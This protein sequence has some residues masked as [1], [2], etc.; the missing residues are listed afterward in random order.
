M[1]DLLA[2]AGPSAYWY[3]TR[4][5]GAVALLL[6]TISVVLGILGPLRFTAGPRWPRFAIDSLHRDISLLVIVLLVAH[7]ITSVLDT[8]AP[9]KLIDAIIPFSSAY[10][11]L[12]VGLGALSF[13]LIIAL[14]VT[15]LMRRRLGYGAW[16]AIHWLAYASWPVAVL[17]GIGTGSD[18]K[19]WW[20]LGLTALC[21]VAVTAAVLMR[22]AQSEGEWRVPAFALAVIAPVG[23]ALFTLA[24]PLQHGW[25]RKAG[26]PTNLLGKTFTPVAAQLPAR[27]AK[28]GSHRRSGGASLKVPFSA[29]LRGSAKQTVEQ[30]GAI[31]DLSLRLSGGAHGRL[32]VRLAGTPLDG[33]GLSLTGSQVDLLADGLPS[34]LA[35][36]IVQLEGQQFIARVHDGSGS[37]YNLHAELNIDGQSGHVTGQLAASAAGG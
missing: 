32:R 28:A 5:T 37:N 14:I 13:D 4:A 33:G 6:L 3:L 27:A 16:R 34:V 36:H 1:S 12:W 17:H 18:T 10:R 23:I 11:P 20:M 35:G 24:G 22:I 8:F 26:T 31:V 21:V 19:T 25:A 7:I 9:I 29:D 15:S 2:V 30:G